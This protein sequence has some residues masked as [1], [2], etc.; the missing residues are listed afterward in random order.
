MIES[1]KIITLPDDVYELPPLIILKYLFHLL[2]LLSTL[3][4]VIQEPKSCLV[5][6]NVKSIVRLIGNNKTNKD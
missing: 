3:Q 2:P 5:T 4:L 6:F 1:V